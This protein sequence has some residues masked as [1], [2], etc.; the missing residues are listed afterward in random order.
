MSA[1]SS[2]SSA[3][4]CSTVGNPG[5]C[6]PSAAPEF[7]KPAEGTHISTV[8]AVGSGKGG[9]GKSTVTA[10]M[11]VMLTRAGYKVGILDA[12]VTGPSMGQAF[13]LYE[14]IYGNET[15]QFIPAKTLTGIKIIS[16][17]LLLPN[18]ED[19]V[20][21]RGPVISQVIR[22]FYSDV[23]WG[24]LDVLLI[25]MP[26]GTGDVPLTIFQSFPVDR[27]AVV[28]TPQ[29]LVSLIVTKACKMATM[30]HVPI[31]GL[32]E[33]MSYFKD[34]ETGKVFYPFGKGRGEE[35]AQKMEIKYLEGLGI[36]A[37]ITEAIDRGRIE[38]LQQDLLE[39]P[40]KEISALIERKRA[41]RERLKAND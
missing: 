30:M 2:C 38:T 36:D 4:S 1:C 26:P 24:E 11:A 5:S 37:R 15:G 21:W 3:S 41:I 34:E 7:L 39:V 28:T 29:D 17:N 20:V 14:P 23:S 22:Q 35:S 8:V 32:I 9:V 25:D 40:V 6:G 10:L 31:L 16:L 19:P 27:Y 13:G 18:P 12:D 33:N